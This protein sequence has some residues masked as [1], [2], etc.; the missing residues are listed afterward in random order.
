MKAR[1]ADRKYSKSQMN[2]RRRAAADLEEQKDGPWWSRVSAA[3]GLSNLT[4]MA[5]G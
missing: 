5:N 2:A 4:A 1:E 3:F